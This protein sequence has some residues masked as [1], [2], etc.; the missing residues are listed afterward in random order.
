MAMQ[1]DTHLF[2]QFLLEEYQTYRESAKL[3]N[4]VREKIFLKTLEEYRAMSDNDKQKLLSRDFS[5]INLRP[6]THDEIK[7]DVAKNLKGSVLVFEYWK[8]KRHE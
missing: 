8:G 6:T 5:V 2:E 1:N 7:R 4:T 3:P